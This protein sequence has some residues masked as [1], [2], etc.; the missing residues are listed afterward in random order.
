M[1]MF[2]GLLMKKIKRLQRP[3]IGRPGDAL[4]SA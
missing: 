2:S 4:K 3:P 1:I